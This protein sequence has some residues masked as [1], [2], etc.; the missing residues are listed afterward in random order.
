MIG[1]ECSEMYSRSRDLDPC[2]R[3]DSTGYNNECHVDGR[4]N[5]LNL[6]VSIPLSGTLKLR[7]RFLEWCPWN[8]LDRL[9]RAPKRRTR[10]KQRFREIKGRAHVVCYALNKVVVSM[11]YRN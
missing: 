1:K 6:G 10:V 5:L 8:I 3:E 2:L 7:D 4:V 9:V 11:S